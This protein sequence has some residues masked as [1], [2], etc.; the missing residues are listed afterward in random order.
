[1]PDKVNNLL[2]G[3]VLPALAG[4]L[5]TRPVVAF[6]PWQLLQTTTKRP[7]TGKLLWWWPWLARRLGMDGS[8]S[9]PLGPQQPGQRYQLV[10]A[11]PSAADL[12]RN[13]LVVAAGTAFVVFMINSYAGQLRDT[14]QVLAELKS[15]YISLS[16]GYKNLNTQL[17]AVQQQVTAASVESARSQALMQQLATRSDNVARALEGL[18]NELQRATGR[19]GYQQ[20]GT[21]PV[22]L[23]EF[24][25]APPTMAP[26]NQSFSEQAMML[27]AI[28]RLFFRVG[29]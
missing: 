17:Q 20:Q 23:D 8:G 27:P 7:E 9:G 28:H 18:R 25:P 1:M 29:R 14:P 2:L 22:D 13:P 5:A 3:A 19:T 21:P 4:Y 10:P 11:Q 24:A 26:R 12:F 16:D 6:R 15:N